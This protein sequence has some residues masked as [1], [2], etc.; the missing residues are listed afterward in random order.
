MGTGAGH[1]F[2]SHVVDGYGVLVV[3]RLVV[4]LIGNFDESGG[5]DVEGKLFRTVRVSVPSRQLQVY[6]AISLTWSFGVA[7]GRPVP[8]VPAP[9]AFLHTPEGTVLPTILYT[10]H[11]YKG[12]Y[13][14]HGIHQQDYTSVVC[15]V[16]YVQRSQ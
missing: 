5:I 9:G 12:W 7:F 2:V 13:S 1:Q 4:A 15:T 11:G 16:G 14:P 6:E 3:C 10:P 8:G